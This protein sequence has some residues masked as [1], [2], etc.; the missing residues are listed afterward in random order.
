MIVVASI[1]DRDYHIKPIERFLPNPIIYDNS[2]RA[3]H[4]LNLKPDLVIAWKSGN[5]SEDL[6]QMMMLLI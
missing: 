2:Q 6:A 1:K 4:L 5:Q 3:S